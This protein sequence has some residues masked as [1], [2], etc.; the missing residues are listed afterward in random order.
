MRSYILL[1]FK[2]SSA[3]ITLMFGALLFKHTIVYHFK[4]EENL[5]GSCKDIAHQTH[6][7][8]TTNTAKRA[9]GNIPCVFQDVCFDLFI[10]FVHDF[11]PL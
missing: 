10:S 8:V 11:I 4:V 5:I 2:V 9:S 1:Y 7:T 3:S 6:T